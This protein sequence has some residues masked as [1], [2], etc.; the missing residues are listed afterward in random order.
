M[1]GLNRNSKRHVKIK[2][3]SKT[4][5]EVSSRST[6]AQKTFCV[7]YKVLKNEHPQYLFRLIPIRRTLYSTR[8]MY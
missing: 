3:L 4:G 7:F 1:P 8:N 6:F 2:N 5:F